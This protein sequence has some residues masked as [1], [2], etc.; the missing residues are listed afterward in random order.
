M[1]RWSPLLFLGSVLLL[2]G[3]TALD[4]VT[5]PENLIPLS[6]LPANYGELVTVLHS[7]GDKRAA[8]WDELWFENKDS[9]TLTRVYLFRP[10]WSWDPSFVKQITRTGA[11]TGTGR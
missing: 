6:E 9:G 2:A 8:Q 1:P 7:P 11:Q 10:T 5:V 4:Q 3:C